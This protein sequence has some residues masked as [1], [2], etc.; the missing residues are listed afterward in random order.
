MRYMDGIKDVDTSALKVALDAKDYANIYKEAEAL[1]EQGKKILSL[2]RLDNPILV[3][4]NY[5][6]SEAIAVNS[7]VEARLARESASCFQENDFSNPRSDGSKNIKNTTR[8]KL[9]KMRIRK[10]CAL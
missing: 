10:N 5:S 1:K 7:A 3:A 4:R 6:M 8:G 9:P 2:S